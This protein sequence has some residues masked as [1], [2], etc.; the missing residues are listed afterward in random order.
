MLADCFVV[1]F[2]FSCCS[3]LWLPLT[4]P[5]AI[6]VT[7]W[8]K[9][10]ERRALTPHS[11]AC[12]KVCGPAE[13]RSSGARPRTPRTAHTPRARGSRWLW[14]GICLWSAGGIRRTLASGPCL[15][16]WGN[17]VTATHTH[18]VS[19]MEHATFII[20]KSATSFFFCASVFKVTKCELCWAMSGIFSWWKRCPLWLVNFGNFPPTWK[21]SPKHGNAVR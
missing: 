13:S 2:L 3:C 18:T 1:V 10:W 20:N 11:P 16:W 12:S 15:Q 8:K 6:F 9:W 4:F 19:N 21:Q 7:A 17:A 5:K 14:A